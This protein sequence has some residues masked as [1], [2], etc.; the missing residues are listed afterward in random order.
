MILRMS[1]MLHFSL[2][3]TKAKVEK[4]IRKETVTQ[5][6][7]A[8][9]RPNQDGILDTA[10]GANHNSANHSGPSLLKERVK[11]KIRAN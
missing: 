6:A 8:G 4:A 9:T 1:R 5:V 11:G 10:I 2:G 7:V 3:S